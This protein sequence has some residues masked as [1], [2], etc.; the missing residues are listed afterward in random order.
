MF[1]P[2]GDVDNIAG[3]LVM[4]E[5]QPF[6]LW[7]TPSVM[8]HTMGG[9]FGVLNAGLV[10]RQTVELEEPIDTGLGFTITPFV[11]PGKI[12][13]YMESANEAEIELGAES[14]A[15]VGLKFLMATAVVL[16]I[17]HPARA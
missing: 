13:L 15:T 3:L 5:M 7:A 17:S 14:D 16:I 4:R 9:V 1:A 8:A 6:T 2:N 11:T 12:P 10:K